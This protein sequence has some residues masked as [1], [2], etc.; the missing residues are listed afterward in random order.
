M[1]RRLA[2][3]AQ[4]KCP[5]L[6]TATAPLVKIVLIDKSNRGPT[7]RIVEA[8]SEIHRQN[9]NGDLDYQIVPPNQAVRTVTGA[10]VKRTVVMVSL[11]ESELSSRA[12]GDAGPR[13]ACES[14]A[15]AHTLATLRPA[16]RVFL[17]RH[18]DLSS[19]TGVDVV[20]ALMSGIS[21]V[22]DDRILLYDGV[23]PALFKHSPEDR[24]SRSILVIGRS[25]AEARALREMLNAWDVD[26]KGD[27]TADVACW[28]AA[29]A[30]AQL[31]HLLPLAGPN[32]FAF[33]RLAEMLNTLRGTTTFH[34]SE[35]DL[36][37]AL[38]SLADL[39]IGKA[40]DQAERAQL[41]RRARERGFPRCQPVIVGIR[42]ED[43]PRRLY[44]ICKA[45]TLHELALAGEGG[46][47]SL[48]VRL[49]LRQLKQR[50]R[51]D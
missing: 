17:V 14:L 19:L 11:G 40:E 42:D 43:V 3:T 7:A 47:G 1:R 45:M 6:H 33:T 20:A 10:D 35:S 15:A 29:M 51:V 48:L 13:E 25:V 4:S 24:R 23:L 27:G 16:P 21:G 2:A 46:M 34:L 12:S 30:L 28:R 41:P 31:E 38:S 44:D 8:A 37:K 22:L 36:R 18:S 39:W 50:R 49:P 5:T 9:G 32:R 26:L